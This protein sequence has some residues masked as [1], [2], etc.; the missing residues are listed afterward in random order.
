M[1]NGVTEDL[2]DILHC[3][4]GQISCAAAFDHFQ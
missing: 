2:P 1:R 4:L 3:P